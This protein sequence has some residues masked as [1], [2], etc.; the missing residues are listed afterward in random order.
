M[1]K[2]Y[3]WG[4]LM[5]KR[6]KFVTLW[7]TIITVLFISNMGIDCKQVQAQDDTN[8]RVLC[9]LSYNYAYNIVPYETDGIEDGLF[10]DEYNLN[11]TLSYESM[12]A[13]NFYTATDIEK[14][15]DHINYKLHRTD[16]Y[17]LVIVADD[18]ALR[19]AMNN[20]DT[21]FK[22]IPIIFMGINSISDAQ[23]A[24]VLDNVTGV[25]EV[26]DFESN[27]QLMRQL[28]PERNN[29]VAVVDGTNTGQGEYVQFMKFIED[30]PDQAYQIL[31]TSRYSKEGVV[32]YLGELGSN[33]IIL[34]LDFGE[35]GDG[36]IYTL[37]YASELIANSVDNVPI[38]RTSSAN[39]GH[40]VLGGI[41][42]SFYDAG[43]QA[44][45]MAAQVLS[46]TPIQDIDMRSETVTQTYFEQSA[47][48]KYGIKLRQIPED[49]VV[50]NLRFSLIKWYKDNTVLADLLILICLLLLTII[51]I[52]ARNN[53]IS[54][55]IANSD[56]LTGIANRLYMNRLLQNCISH[57]ETFGYIII[58]VDYFKQI[59]DTKGHN[60]GDQVLVEIAKR[61]NQVAEKNA[62][63]AA[64]IGGDEFSILVKGGSRISCSNICQQVKE[65]TK[66][67]IETRGGLVEFTFSIGGA[68]YPEDTNESH[69]VMVLAD[70]ALYKVKKGGRN[71]C[72]MYQAE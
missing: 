4:C 47:M 52:L 70:Q 61:L 62:S 58:D 64:R 8:Y 43:K 54:K 6:L 65:L 16:K 72:L 11:V 40:G 9:I 59:N 15:Y 44:G 25:A 19:F 33:D 7:V 35:D 53:G 39:V 38:F 2:D 45:T 46:G 5:A 14:F 50:I 28:F 67:P 18:S 55:R 51:I 57:N 1:Q 10:S 41:S 3:Y 68:V 24:A 12:D 13:K 29:I 60:V 31:N 32:N 26:T 27:Y 17:D 69:M 42:Y 36:N 23:T 37:E 21:L 34:Y 22:D 56:A 30:H 66:N 20:R 48:D 63:I 71:D 49:S